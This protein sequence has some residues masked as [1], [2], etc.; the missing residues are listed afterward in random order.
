VLGTWGRTH[1]WCRRGT[2]RQPSGGNIPARATPGARCAVASRECQGGKH[3]SA[4]SDTLPGWAG[5][6]EVT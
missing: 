4:A 6:R 3:E 2:R 5:R 1:R